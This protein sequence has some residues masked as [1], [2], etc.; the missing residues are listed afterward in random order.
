MSRG[1][2]PI[3]VSC[4]ALI[5]AN[6]AGMIPDVP[7]DYALPIE[8]IL[9]NT[10]C[11]LQ[12]AFVELSLNKDLAS[13]HAQSWLIGLTL[14]PKTDKEIVAG[15]GLSGKS[16]SLASPRYV[17]SWASGAATLPGFNSDV[18]GT[19]NAGVTYNIHSKDLLDKKKFQLDCDP[20]TPNYNA[21]A[22]NLGVRKWLIRTVEA[23]HN[24]V[25]SLAK[26]D[27]PT[28]S[29]EIYVKFNA[30]GNFTYTFPF[31]TDFASLSGSYDEDIT[32]SIAI[33]GDQSKTSV[34]KV[35]S[36][37]TGGNFG[38]P[39]PQNLQTT[40]NV[41]AQSRLDAIEAQQQIV[42]QLKNIN[43]NSRPR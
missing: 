40:V 43:T 33:T 18:R 10:T 5:S 22:D 15:V 7:N 30:G 34:I 28:F 9:H 23:Q 17:N 3:F 6:C 27:K 42:N 31:G 36:L 12:K 4:F 21:L 35:Q 38:N 29:S 13:F 14:S 39:D 1:R 41:G 37:P 20:T 8:D 26:L 24:S 19:R 11:E 2:H 32:F 25:G 16:S